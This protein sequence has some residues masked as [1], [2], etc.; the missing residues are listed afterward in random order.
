M[1][2]DNHHHD[3]RLAIW[4]AAPDGMQRDLIAA[5]PQR[6]FRPPYVGHRGWIGARLDITPDWRQIAALVTD[7]YRIVAPPK[8][9][10]RLEAASSR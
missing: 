3:G 10:A 7:A 8:L 1:F 2:M 4:C 6:Y 9:V 5:D